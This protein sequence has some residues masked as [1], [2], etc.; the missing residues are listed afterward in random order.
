MRAARSKSRSPRRAPQFD[1]HRE[2]RRARA[3]RDRVL[4]ATSRRRAVHDRTARDSNTTPQVHRGSVAVVASRV[5]LERHSHPPQVR[6]QLRTVSALVQVGCQPV[7]AYLRRVGASPLLVLRAGM[8]DQVRVQDTRR[9]AASM[10]KG[11]RA[12]LQKRGVRTTNRRKVRRRSRR[13][14][15]RG[16][17][18]STAVRAPA[19][20]LYQSASI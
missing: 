18:A 11:L 6:Q 17:A 7:A 4:P 8:A 12:W 1:L 20:S 15:Q 10:P 19:L 13:P 14:P 5:E 2:V 3:P 9:R 16:L